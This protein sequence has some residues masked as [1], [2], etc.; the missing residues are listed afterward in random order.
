MP[1][2]DSLAT[3]PALAEL[4]SDN[5]L[6]QAM[7]DFE[8]ELACVEARAGIIPND[9]ADAIALSAQAGYFDA[10]A[11][12]HDTLRAGTPGIPLVKALTERVRAEHPSAAGYV[13][14]GATSQDVADTA[15]VLVLKK[16]QAL[17]EA[18][19]LRAEAALHRL[20]GQHSHTV[21]LGRTLLQ[22]GPP[23]T[24]GVKAAGWLGA[25]WRSRTRLNSAFRE[26]LMLQFGGA[27]GTLAS[28][29][30][31]G[32][33]IS[34]ALAKQ[35]E[36]GCPEAP[37]H[38]HRDRLASLICACGVVTGSLAKIARDISL[39]MQE[40]VG[41]VAEPS[42]L[43]RGGSSAMPH[44]RNP[45]GCSLTLAAAHRVPG[46]VASFLSA[47][48]QEHERAAGGWQSE[49]PTVAG[50]IQATGLAAASMAEVLEG[51]TVNAA[52]MRA[53]I[54][55]TNGTIFAER[56]MMLLAPHLGRDAAHKLLEEAVRKALEQKRSL[57]EVL[58][59]MPE[60]RRLPDRAF[61]ENLD[62]PEEYLGVAEQFRTR[63]LETQ[64]PHCT[65]DKKE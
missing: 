42:A 37:W 46:I 19:I 50:I 28:L 22:S 60:A 57:R 31:R 47:M 2:I 36:L 34:T 13:H 40:E 4:F 43:G 11:I 48:T 21:M 49:W 8:A 39:L 20:A 52:R 44:K 17:V 29:G 56:A 9:A 65:E 23:I 38:T 63:L 24:F 33:E 15:L 10:E 30:D 16:A 3:T 7:L 45:I 62:V 55:A 18:D 5:S 27:S 14:W 53:N 64:K 35:L 25:I 1:L 26:A 54:E 61:L 6:L 58:G 32:L 12:T 51:L 59:E 41:E